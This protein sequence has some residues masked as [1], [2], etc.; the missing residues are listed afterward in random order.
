M[1]PQFG[2]LCPGEWVYHVYN[3]DE[4]EF[5]SLGGVATEPRAAR[6][7]AK[8][9][10]HARFTLDKYEGDFYA[11]TKRGEPPPKLEPPF[12][13]IAR[14][15]HGT[16]IDLCDIEPG[17]ADWVG[18]LGGHSCSAYDVTAQLF[19]GECHELE[20]YGV[21][22]DTA[23]SQKLRV[24]A[25]YKSSCTANSWVDFFLNIS[26]AEVLHNN[27]LFEVM[28]DESS[29]Q[30]PNAV[31]VSIFEGS[32][33][34]N[35]RSLFTTDVA[36]SAGVLSL[37]VSSG[38]MRRFNV[39][40]A[41]FL[42]VHCGAED[43][44][45]SALAL[46]VEPEV[47][48][49][50]AIHGEVCLGVWQYFYFDVPAAI[51]YSGGVKFHINK[52]QGSASFITRREIRPSKLGY[53][54]IELNQ[55][56]HDGEVDI[57][58]VHG[59]ERIWLAVKGG[60]TC[61]T[62]EVD[63]ALIANLEDCHDQRDA[64]T[65]IVN[66]HIKMAFDEWEYD[67]CQEGN[68]ALHDFIVE[69]GVESIANNLIVEVEQIVEEGSNDPRALQVF[70]FRGSTTGRDDD[71]I[72]KSGRAFENV[73]AFGANYIDLK[74]RW[75]GDYSF[76]VKCGGGAVKFRVIAKLLHAI[77]VSESFVGGRVCP[78]LWTYH[79]YV[80][81][82]EVKVGDEELRVGEE[83]GGGDWLRFKIRVLSGDLYTVAARRDY[84]PAFN[85]INAMQ[86]QLPAGMERPAA[87]GGEGVV[88]VYVDIC[89]HVEGGHKYY[90][91]LY[92]ADGGCASYEVEA[93][94]MTGAGCGN[95]TLVV[96]M[97]WGAGVEVE[98][99]HR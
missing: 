2:E 49:G 20:H 42:S 84:P 54:F 65:S 39:G 28:L 33:P 17:H 13:Y 93:L 34:E 44:Q 5:A 58:D 71:A 11:L 57:C 85:S 69:V 10:V 19:T 23:G 55:A 56:D 46:K 86:L 83:V 40:E 90:V 91:G 3:V 53:P 18:I 64:S 59:G 45:F 60:R 1:Q 29:R 12:A 68:Y 21:V 37:S 76:A 99:P 51:S 94:E 9:G 6:Y 15:S 89:Q 77:L 32:I 73:Y 72:W 52:H 16:S 63:V 14:K 81:E 8:T 26:D 41:L 97:D 27:F 67:E 75:G 80:H 96:D 95:E 4:A 87:H 78:G 98:V 25:S 31:T 74:Y 7:I 66:N 43:T 92:G 70:G 61:A 35:R 79:F 47:K 30:N 36:N 38:R 88:D 62:F 24:D 50:Q 82:G 22:E 48:V